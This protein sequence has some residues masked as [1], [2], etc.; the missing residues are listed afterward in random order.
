MSSARTDNA[1]DDTSA[2][3]VIVAR[4]GGIA[5]MRREWR[6]EPPPTEESHWIALI[7][8]CPWDAAP[9]DPGGADRF[10]W[11]IEAHCGPQQKQAQLPDREV[12]GPWRELVDEVRSFGERSKPPAAPGPRGLPVPE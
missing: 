8:G 9:G 5:G 10:V 6:A 4:T 3:M 2:L 11:N 7:E 12:Q 1:V